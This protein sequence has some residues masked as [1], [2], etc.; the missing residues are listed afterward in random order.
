MRK[1][2]G[3]SIYGS[4]CYAYR[5]PDSTSNI[6]EGDNSPQGIMVNLSQVMPPP[7]TLGNNGPPNTNL[8]PIPVKRTR[9]SFQTPSTPLKMSSGLKLRNQNQN[10]SG[11]GGLR[12]NALGKILPPGAI[13]TLASP[14]AASSRD[15]RV[16][17]QIVAQPEEQHRGK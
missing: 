6:A 10:Q 12:N 2:I 8:S 3:R 17:L 14:L 15:G 1:V 9:F 4:Y 11:S 7:M 13:P 5:S 16:Q